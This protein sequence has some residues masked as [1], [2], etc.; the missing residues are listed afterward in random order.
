MYT[1]MHGSLL[2]SERTKAEQLVASG[3]T[4]NHA[5]MNPCLETRFIKL[6]VNEDIERMKAGFQ[7]KT[8][9]RPGAGRTT[10]N[11]AKAC[12]VRVHERELLLRLRNEAQTQDL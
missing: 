12:Y 7:T 6:G 9:C 3:C 11:H 8:A 1:C 2:P 4:V 10:A 5:I